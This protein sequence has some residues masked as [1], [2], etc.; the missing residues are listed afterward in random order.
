MTRPKTDAVAEARVRL[1]GVFRG[2]S[3]K[4]RLTLRLEE[5]AS[6]GEVVQ[7]LVEALPPEFGRALV[8]PELGDPRPNALILVNGREISALKGLQ[9]EVDDGYEITLIPVS[10]GG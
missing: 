8:D 4:G 5:P 10:H 6:V 2:L 3:G 7:R 1:L 9:T